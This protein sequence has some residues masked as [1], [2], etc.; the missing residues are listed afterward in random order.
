[1]CSSKDFPISGACICKDDTTGFNCEKC[2]VGWYGNALQGTPD[3]CT[4]C[5]CPGQG[6]CYEQ[7]SVRSLEA[8]VHV[9]VCLF[10]RIPTFSKVGKVST[11]SVF[12]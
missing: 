4:A 2:K 8:G 12:T 5:P 6:P 11:M 1:M 7:V 9:L 3:D 10:K